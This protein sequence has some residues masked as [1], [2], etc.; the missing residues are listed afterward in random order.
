MTADTEHPY[1]GLVAGSRF[2]YF[3]GYYI[4]KTLEELLMPQLIWE[5]FV[6]VNT[7][8]NDVVQYYIETTTG[9]GTTRGSAST[10]VKKRQTPWRADGAEFASVEVSELGMDFKTMAQRGLE[11]KISE[12]MRKNNLFDPV[13]RAR[14]RVG[15]WIAEQINSEVGVALTYNYTVTNDNSLA[16]T[17]VFNNITSD[18]TLAR[19]AGLTTGGTLA[20]LLDVDKYWGTADANP[21]LDIMDLGTAMKRQTGY[22]YKMD[23]VLMESGLFRLLKQYLI[24]NDHSWELSPFA[25]REGIVVP[26]IGGVRIVELFDVDGLPTNKIIGLDSRAQPATTFQ[27]F[28]PEFG[29]YGPDNRL[30]FYEYMS[31]ET[32]MKHIQLWYKRVTALIEPKSVALLQVTA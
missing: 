12:A 23:T 24:F 5:S 8:D 11:I 26:A 10:D 9:G 29:T 18:P 13:I 20:G 2:D 30:M 19:G 21:I 6:P 28:N 3:S 17:G 27:T 7:T 25:G 1:A 4:W 16:S 31:D 22:S 32:H 14:T 15:R